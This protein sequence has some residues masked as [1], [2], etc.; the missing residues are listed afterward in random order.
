MHSRPTYLA[1]KTLDMLLTADK[2]CA[3]N[4]RFA[5]MSLY[6]SFRRFHGYPSLMGEYIPILCR[7]DGEGTATLNSFAITRATNWFKLSKSSVSL[8]AVRAPYENMSAQCLHEKAK[9]RRDGQ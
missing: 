1:K 9:S 4:Y 2:L 7:S 5:K 3:D 8:M 6:T